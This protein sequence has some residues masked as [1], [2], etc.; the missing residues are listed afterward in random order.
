MIKNSKSI[1]LIKNQSN[2]KIY[3]VELK[4]KLKSSKK[5]RYLKCDKSNYNIKKCENKK[6]KIHSKKI[7]FDLKSKK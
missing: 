7:T 3:I 4:R 6:F 5:N 1:I 2:L